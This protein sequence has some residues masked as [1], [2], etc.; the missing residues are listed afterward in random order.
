MK[1]TPITEIASIYPDTLIRS[2]KAVK[3]NGGS[4][5]L[6][7]GSLRD[8]S[9]FQ[10]LDEIKPGLSKLPRDEQ[11]I[12]VPGTLNSSNHAG[13]HF[14]H[15][16]RASV[17]VLGNT[18]DVGNTPPEESSLAVEERAKLILGRIK[19]L[20]EFETYQL[21]KLQELFITNITPKPKDLDGR[22]ASN[23]LHA[24]LNESQSRLKQFGVQLTILGSEKEI[25]DAIHSCLGN[26]ELAA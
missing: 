16:Q 9:V 22:R 8:E 20:T 6:L 18:F 17:Q 19:F 3:T 2:G 25:Q 13:F 12:F 4:V 23:Q 15:S 10:R 5:V 1:N 7:G 11:R 21:S 14:I 26:L 24:T